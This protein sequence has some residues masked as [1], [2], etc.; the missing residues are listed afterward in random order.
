[1]RLVYLVTWNRNK[2]M[3]GVSKKRL[4]A[5]SVDIYDEAAFWLYSSLMMNGHRALG[6]DS[7]IAHGCQWL[8]PPMFQAFRAPFS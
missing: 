2:R 3:T 6:R 1:M 4:P 8:A 5:P 7:R